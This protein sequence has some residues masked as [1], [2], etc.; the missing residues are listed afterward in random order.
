MPLARIAAVSEPSAPA[1]GVTRPSC[2]SWSYWLVKARGHLS[3]FAYVLKK[4]IRIAPLPLSPM[5]RCLMVRR[6]RSPTRRYKGFVSH[7]GYRNLSK[8]ND[9]YPTSI[10]SRA[11]VLRVWRSWPVYPRVACR[12]RLEA[13]E[14]PLP[15]RLRHRHSWPS[16]TCFNPEVVRSPRVGTRA[17]RQLRRH[18]TDA[19]VI[20]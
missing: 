10:L 5:A 9:P 2:P 11:W 20:I 13:D 14:S 6:I 7:L 16:L 17:H 1:T 8:S 12:I 19:R 3:N 15:A 4:R 18:H